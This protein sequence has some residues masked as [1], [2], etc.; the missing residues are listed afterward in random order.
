MLRRRD[1]ACSREEDHRRPVRKTSPERNHWRMDRNS[2]DGQNAPSSPGWAAGGGAEVR[3]GGR[4][5]E[6][7]RRKAEEVMQTLTN[8]V[9]QLIVTLIQFVQSEVPVVLNMNMRVKPA[10]NRLHQLGDRDNSCH[11]HLST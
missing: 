1:A 2:E 5:H 8:L 11:L 4:S 3:G 7:K 10:R 6:K 9:I